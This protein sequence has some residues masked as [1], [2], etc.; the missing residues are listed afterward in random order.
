MEKGKIIKTT[1]QA[2]SLV[3]IVVVGN[4]AYKAIDNQL[5]KRSEAP[6]APVAPVAPKAT[7]AKEE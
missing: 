3:A 6:V 1:I 7:V 5:A 4:F 2:L